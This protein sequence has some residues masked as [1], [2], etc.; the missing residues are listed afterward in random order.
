M[1][2][3]FLSAH[4]ADLMERCRGMV[5]HRQGPHVAEPRREIGIPLFMEQLIATLRAQEADIPRPMRSR[6]EAPPEIGFAAAQNGRELFQLGYTIEQVV[7]CYGDLC[8]AVTEL[9]SEVGATIRVEEFKVMNLC[10]D[11]A[12]AGAVAGYASR[13]DILI[14]EQGTQSLNERLGFLA[15][16]LRNH[17]HTATLA[18][19]ALKAANMGRAGATTGVLDRS[20]IA[21]RCLVDRTLSDVRVAAGPPT[22]Q[23][24]MSVADFIT[25][26]TGT[27]SLE[28]QAR[29]CTLTA[30]AVDPAL[31]VRADRDL[32]SSAVGNLLQN[33]FKF[34]RPG[35]EVSLTAYTIG[36]RIRI[37]VKDCC[38]GLPPGDPEELFKP[39]RQSG[40]DRSGLGLGLSISRRS[41]EA[42]RGTLTAED[43]PG[44][45]CKFVI[46]L[47][48]FTA[49]L[50]AVAAREMNS[51]P[52]TASSG[53]S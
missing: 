6:G 30:A 1:L 53:G 43:L 20:L 44:E 24:V 5:S 48:R 32:L 34:T 9:A 49:P 15:H 37:E 11:F 7:H 28:A 14:S 16:E 39:F 8:Q 23:Q 17:I 27:A 10:L 22:P 46:D 13:H 36:D 35:S 29:Q 3:S 50:S 42:N 40:N 25:E 47:P 12:I 38:G 33:A 52:L 51:M 2:H 26:I 21:L 31:E 4:R 18:V 45:G 41:A 19:T